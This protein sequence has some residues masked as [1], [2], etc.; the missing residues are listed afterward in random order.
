M[1]KTVSKH[2][3]MPQELRSLVGG[4]AGFLVGSLV[5]I[6]GFLVGSLI[7]V[8]GFVVGSLVRVSGYFLWDLFRDT[9][10][11]LWDPCGSYCFQIL[12]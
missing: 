6:S 11:K 5:G 10:R 2:Q 3:V 8:S 4:G 7:G 9:W 1:S 12:Y